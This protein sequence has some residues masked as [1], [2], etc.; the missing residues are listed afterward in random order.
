MT[1]EPFRLA[2]FQ[3]D[4]AWE[5]TE[6]NLKKLESATSSIQAG[7]VDLIVLPEMFSTG[8][9]MNPAGKA[10]NEIEGALNRLSQITAKLQTKVAGS[11][12]YRDG[13]DYKNRFL[14]ID[15]NGVQDFYDKRHLFAL[16]KETSTYQ[17]GS[18]KKLWTIAGWRVSPFVCYDLR[19]PE[20]CRNDQNADL[21]LFTANW[22][23]ARAHHWRSL[24]VARAIENQCYVAGVNRVGTDG[25]QL[26][27]SGNSLVFNANGETLLDAGEKEG[28][29]FVSLSNSN[30]LEFREKYPFLKD[31]LNSQPE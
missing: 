18:E 4:L 1:A 12:I 2:L 15:Q 10:M 3:C 21:I 20:W 9:S 17:P 7:S 25:N 16:G 11:F 26:S 6:F 8:F 5:N 30:Q 23:Q 29:H 19:F 28:L 27:Y 13:S 14:L 31:R 24:L 22:P